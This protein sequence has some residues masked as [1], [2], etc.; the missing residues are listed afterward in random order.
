MPIRNLS[1]SYHPPALGA[2]GTTG[3]IDRTGAINRTV[4]PTRPSPSAPLVRAVLAKLW[5]LPSSASTIA[6]GNSLT[7]KVFALNRTLLFAINC[8]E[9]FLSR[10]V[11]S[12]EQ[13]KKKHILAGLRYLLSVIS[14]SSD[15]WQEVNLCTLP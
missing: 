13:L 14:W 5:A 7:A 6:I 8:I 3:A 2:N 10:F 11:H 9:T 12:V 4:P 1:P 15:V